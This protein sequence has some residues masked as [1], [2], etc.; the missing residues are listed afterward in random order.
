[1]F[2]QSSSAL[3]LLEKSC[4]GQLQRLIHGLHSKSVWFGFG[5]I[6]LFIY[7]LYSE[8]RSF[9]LLNDFLF[10]CFRV[11]RTASELRLKTTNKE[12]EK[13][14][15]LL[16]PCLILQLQLHSIRQSVLIFQ[17][18]YYKVF[19]CKNS[20]IQENWICIIICYSW[21]KQISNFS[22]PFP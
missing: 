13:L 3:L 20:D 10:Y 21:T 15:S 14:K 1:M 9:Y 22:Q 7:T 18:P 19:K 11:H 16:L 4:P 5:F 6:Y 2:L 8:V 17:V 12:L